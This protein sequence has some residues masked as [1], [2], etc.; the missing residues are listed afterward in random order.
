[1]SPPD[2]VI[3]L[4]NEKG[5]ITHNNLEENDD[6]VIISQDTNPT[7]SWLARHR[8]LVR[9]VKLSVMAALILGW[10]ISA[11][12]LLATRHRWIVQTVFAWAFIAIIAFRVIPNSVVT[13][14]V[15]AVWVPLVE[16]P[17]FSLPR[18]AR[19]GLG[20][21]AVVAIVM[22]SAFGHGVEN[23]CSSRNVLFL[24]NTRPSH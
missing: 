14:P 9:C 13:R 21:L 24:L 2:S 19:Y 1:M 23:V 12:V 6:K 3:P 20:W 18:F 22:S 8:G 5:D 17:F 7:W 4:P 10:W 16:R 11:T 15:K